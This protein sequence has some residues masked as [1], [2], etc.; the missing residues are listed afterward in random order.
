L[1]ALIYGIGQLFSAIRGVLL[2]RAA[3]Q[4]TLDLRTR[5]Y[6]KLQGQSAGYF[7]TRRTGDLLARRTGDVNSISEILVRADSVFDA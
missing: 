3:Q 1:L 4:L 2:E 7:A 5:L 6:A